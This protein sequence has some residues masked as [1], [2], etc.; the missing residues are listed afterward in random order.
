MNKIEL[1]EK[2]LRNKNKI[3]RQAI[4]NEMFQYGETK[5]LE[6][7]LQQERLNYQI[8]NQ[9]NDNI[10][11]KKTHKIININNI[12]NYE[13]EYPLK[14][15]LQI[16]FE[17]IHNQLNDILLGSKSVIINNME[18]WSYYNNIYLLKVNNSYKY[19][20]SELKENW[21]VKKINVIIYDTKYI[22]IKKNYIYLTKYINTYK[23]YIFYIEY[24][25]K[26]YKITIRN[27]KERQLKFIGYNKYN[28]FI[29]Y[30]NKIEE[31]LKLKPLKYKNIIKYTIKT[32]E[33]IKI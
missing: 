11:Y 8:L 31:I 16:I 22:K 15:N 7:K 12:N 9:D 18:E 27:K 19:L 28:I 33:I 25:I 4:Y 10:I 2:L 13:Y 1:L 21:I 30:L 17:D 29:K 23:K 3:E 32:K 24:I 5:Y 26:I 14:I 20:Q 6:Y